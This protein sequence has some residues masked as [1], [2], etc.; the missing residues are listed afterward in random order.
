[1]GFHSPG[2]REARECLD[3]G[4]SRHTRHSGFNRAGP[5]PA[6]VFGEPPQE[7]FNAGAAMVGMGA[8]FGCSGAAG[9]NLFVYVVYLL[10]CCYVVLICVIS[11][12]FLTRQ[13]E[14]HGATR[15]E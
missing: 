9:G 14:T 3:P 15:S 10:C 4:D 2:Q 7:R 5:P 13:V 8:S 12:C 11:C 1:M 6:W